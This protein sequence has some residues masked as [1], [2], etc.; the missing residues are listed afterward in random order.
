MDV[1]TLFEDEMRVKDCL[2]YKTKDDPNLEIMGELISKKEIL[3]LGC[4]G[5]REVKELV[6]QGH[7]VT[8][9]DISENMIALSKKIEPQAV[10]HCGDAV[11]F[12][13]LN[14]AKLKFDYILGLYAFLGYIEDKYCAELIKNLMS[15]LKKDGTLIFELRRV[16]ESPKYIFKSLVAPF[17]ALYFGKSWKFGDVYGRNAHAPKG[18]WHR[19]HHFTNSELR[20]LFRGYNLKINFNKVYVKHK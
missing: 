2:V 15:M 4:G 10:Y 16:T 5:G 12:A 7:K 9:I 20:K 6:K 14:K 17:F 8:A 11:L 1:K 13:R 18:G 19:G 3:S